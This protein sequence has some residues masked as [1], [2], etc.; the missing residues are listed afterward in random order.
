MPFQPDYE[1]AP[2]RLPYTMAP[3]SAQPAGERVGVLMLHGFMGSPLSSRPMAEYLSRQG[4]FVH[5]PLLP[6]H[7][8]YPA[9]FH[10]VSRRRWL[11][12]VEEAF[13]HVSGNVDELFVTG[14]SMGN[15]LGAHVATRHV[16]AVKGMVMLAPV[17]DV[18][19]RRLRYV[20]V[21]R[22]F[23]TWYY[24]HKSKRESMQALVRERV[25][26][27]DPTIDFDD[28]E[29]QAQLPELSKVPLSG[30]HEMVETI[31]YGRTLWPRLDLPALLFAGDHDVA[32]PPENARAILAALPH[33]DKQLVV[34]PE[35][36]HEMMRPSDPAHPD[37]WARIA[38]FIRSHASVDLPE[39]HPA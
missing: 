29:F 30:M 33:E 10:N 27:F 17:Y 22:H 8:S 28:P 11:A 35:A 5:C 20:G 13:A 19:D 15:I 36:G 32:A 34:Y 37:V 24:P 14:H 21:G 38:G 25:L 6:G 16:G 23:I 12:E 4:I 3:V 39:P 9:R 2:E 7:G 1:V 31:K 18:P 26:D